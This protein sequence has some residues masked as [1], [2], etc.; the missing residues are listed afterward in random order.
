M[1]EKIFPSIDVIENSF[2]EQK[3]NNYLLFAVRSMNDEAFDHLVNLILNQEH[4]KT[5]RLDVR[6]NC[7]TNDSLANIKKLMNHHIHV[8]AD[9]NNFEF[10]YDN[11]ELLSHITD[12]TYANVVDDDIS[13]QHIKQNITYVAKYFTTESQ[14][15]IRELLE[16]T[17]KQKVLS[18]S[19]THSFL[20]QSEEKSNDCLDKLNEVT[21]EELQKERMVDVISTI[22]EKYAQFNIVKQNE[23]DISDYLEDFHEGILLLTEDRSV[24][25]VG[26][27]KE[28]ITPSDL[29]QIENGITIVE[30]KR[31]ENKLPSI[32]KDVIHVIGLVGGDN[33]DLDL[34][35]NQNTL[36]NFIIV[37]KDRN[38]SIINQQILNSI[39]GKGS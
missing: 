22:T 15:Q 13:P 28:N 32:L 31:R 38:Y 39:V 36:Q 16:T 9:S 30:E 24:L 37:S 12:T 17:A 2:N 4:I 19:R 20:S 6:Y 29:S 7:L 34:E 26:T 35:K 21:S 8:H 3:E 27:I 10:D 11:N 33:V 5:T 23:V 1:T 25:M 18:E 14:T